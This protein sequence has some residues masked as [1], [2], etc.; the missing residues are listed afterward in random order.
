MPSNVA[1]TAPV[2]NVP[3]ATCQPG[4]G[5]TRTQLTN[6]EVRDE[7]VLTGAEVQ[8]MPLGSVGWLLPGR[9]QGQI[10]G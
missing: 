8:A 2:M 10:T 1:A 9:L 3:V 4:H 5:T 6:R 7:L